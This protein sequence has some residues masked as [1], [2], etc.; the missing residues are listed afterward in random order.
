M[1]DDDIDETTEAKSTEDRAAEPQPVSENANT[2]QTRQ[3]TRTIEETIISLMLFIPRLFSE[4]ARY[5]RPEL[6]TTRAARQLLKLMSRGM[7]EEFALQE[8]INRSKLDEPE[9]QDLR[10]LLGRVF[11][12]PQPAIFE[13]AFR[14]VKEWLVRATWEDLQSEPFHEVGP[15]IERLSAVSLVTAGGSPMLD[16]RK[17]D[18]ADVLDDILGNEQCVPF[19]FPEQNESGGLPKGSVA[20][21]AGFSHCGKSKLAYYTCLLAAQQG[22]DVLLLDFENNRRSSRRNLIASLSHIPWREVARMSDQERA[23]L[24][25]KLEALPLEL[26]NPVGSGDASRAGIR[27]QLIDYRNRHKKFPDLLV[28]DQ[29]GKIE[30]GQKNASLHEK[31]EAR[32]MA[33]QEIAK[34]FD[35]A[36]MVPHHI[37]REGQKEAAKGKSINEVIDRRITKDFRL[38]GLRIHNGLTIRRP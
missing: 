30:T 14:W 13:D 16:L 11:R 36:V 2:Q 25:T 5:F 33:L 4:L 24:L 34:Q 23:E 17:P 32:I 22:L 38:G 35:V 27:R 19:A 18:W 12:A 15:I 6:F 20:V 31:G 7:I 21:Y 8:A 10:S 28:V 29:L 26:T 3:Y 9:K 1:K 37:N